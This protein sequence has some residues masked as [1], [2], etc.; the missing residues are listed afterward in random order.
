[1]ENLAILIFF[2][3]VVTHRTQWRAMDRELLV[4]LATY[5]IM[6]ALVIGWTTPVMGAVV[7][8]R[9]PMLPFLLISGLLIMDHRK[10]VARWPRTKPLFTS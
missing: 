9:T 4:A 8:Y 2:A 10:L 5:V 7:R 1:M 6:M 3:L